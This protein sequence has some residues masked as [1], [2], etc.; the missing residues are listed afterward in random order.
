[1]CH[2]LSSKFSQGGITVSILH[3]QIAAGL[4]YLHRHQIVHLYM[5]SANVLVW[6]F[7]SPKHDG[8]ITSKQE[9]MKLAGNVWLKL[10]DY[11]ISQVSTTSTIKLEGPAV[12][13]PG[14]MAPEVFHTG[15][16]VSSEK[17]CNNLIAKFSLINQTHLV[18]LLYPY[19]HI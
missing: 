18:V 6:Y 14:Y 10:A 9:R 8:I 16:Q 12:G 1:M 7:P 4:E 3:T 2:K 19:L 5:K 13:T 15:Q 11:G 17:V